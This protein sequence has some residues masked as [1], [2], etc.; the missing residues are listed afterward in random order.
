MKDNFKQYESLSVSLEK[1]MAFISDIHGGLLSLSWLI[2]PNNK[3]DPSRLALFVDNLFCYGSEY[4]NLG[5]KVF[6]V[7]KHREQRL[8]SI[9]SVAL[10]IKVLQQSKEEIKGLNCKSEEDGLKQLT[11][12]CVLIIIKFFETLK[13][14][15]KKAESQINFGPKDVG[16]LVPLTTGHKG[17]PND[18][19]I[20]YIRQV[21][22]LSDFR[23]IPSD[24]QGIS[25]SVPSNLDGLKSSLIPAVATSPDKQP[26][27]ALPK[28]PISRRSP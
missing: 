24:F 4:N 6:S 28:L 8:R 21:L 12:A 25:P 22:R 1:A 20:R 3:Y 17:K 19:E 13:K 7:F 11:L 18:V 16:H 14:Q 2:N 10:I 5:A 9:R 15:L 26:N 27:A 23:Y